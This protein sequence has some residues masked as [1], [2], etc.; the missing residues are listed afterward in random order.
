MQFPELIGG[1]MSAVWDCLEGAAEL[2]GELVEKAVAFV[3]GIAGCLFVL[4]TLAAL[5][6]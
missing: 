5:F 1:K 3:F 4:L 2:V 6:G